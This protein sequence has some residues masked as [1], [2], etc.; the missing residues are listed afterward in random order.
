MKK[1]TLTY[2]IIL[3]NCVALLAQKAKNDNVQA[4]PLSIRKIIS[5]L[6]L[7]VWVI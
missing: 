7:Q 6:F 2:T 4:S 3:L 1:I 5:F